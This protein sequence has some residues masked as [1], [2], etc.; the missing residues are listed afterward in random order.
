MMTINMILDFIQLN[1]LRPKKFFI[2]TNTFHIALLGLLGLDLINLEIPFLRQFVSIVYLIFIPGFIILRLLRIYDLHPIENLLYAIGLSI[3]FLM[4]IGYMANNLYPLIGVTSPL[5]TVYVLLSIVFCLLFLG[6]VS[7]F[8]DN[9]SAKTKNFRY[10]RYEYEEKSSNFTLFL[11]LIPLLSILG[12]YFVNFYGNNILLLSNI[13]IISL[14]FILIIYDKIPNEFNELAIFSI[15]LSLLF[16]NSLISSY[17][18]GWDIF[19]E[20]D[21]ANLVLTNSFWDQ[22]L[23]SSVS[24]VASI[25]LFVPIFCKISDLSLTWFF[26]I[27][28]PLLYSIVPL[29]LYEVF[30]K[31]TSEKTAFVGCFLI[32]STFSFFGEMLSLVRQGISEIFLVLFLLL[33][34]NS[35]MNASVKNVLKLIFS[36]SL[37]LTHYGLSYIFLFFVSLTFILTQLITYINIKFIYTYVDQNFYFNKKN[38]ISYSFVLFCFTATISWYLYTSDS[39]SF[40]YFVQMWKTIYTNFFTDFLSLEST[41][42]LKLLV[43]EQPSVLH[44]ITKEITLLT[45]AFITLGFITCIFNR[46]KKMFDWEYICFT[47]GALSLNIAGLI[48]PHFAISLNFSRIYHISLILLAPF[49]AIGCYTFLYKLNFKRHNLQKFVILLIL[50]P[51]FLFH[52]GFVF[53]IVNDQPSSISLSNEKYRYFFVHES[54][55]Y[56]ADWLSKSSRF[57][58]IYGDYFDILT[59]R[60]YSPI[61]INNQLVFLKPWTQLT[62]N[63]SIY[64]RSGNMNFNNNNSQYIIYSPLFTSSMNKIYN[65][66]CIIYLNS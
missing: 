63:S 44:S 61:P 48:L 30:K 23:S 9:D 26:K 49:F 37:I 20:Y 41:Q 36:L 22:T 58:R 24:S 5:S 1:G 28:Y 54:D 27:I 47:I 32:I 19:G 16:S 56:S 2:V 52:S 25:S 15:T 14:I 33:L 40:I 66:N 42:G 7:Y 17:I 57:E 8:L 10:I 55:L 13:L 39:I 43:Y 59:L 31:Q 21:S 12:T 3:F 64:L 45:Q 65:N 18:W 35:T 11:L 4:L 51:Y 38:T 62:D 50:I 46:N 60:A 53:E 29:G 6:V 34:L